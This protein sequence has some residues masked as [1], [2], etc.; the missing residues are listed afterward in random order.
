V[1]ETVLALDAK[2]PQVAARLLSAFKSWRALES[3]RRE[4]AQ[5]ALRCVVATEDLSADVQDIG[6]RAL[7]E[8]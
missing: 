6:R 2:N 3:G 5:A 4:K 8:G 1:V 7:A